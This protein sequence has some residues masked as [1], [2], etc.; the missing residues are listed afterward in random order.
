MD[1]VAPHRGASRGRAERNAAEGTGLTTKQKTLAGWGFLLSIFSLPKHPNLFRQVVKLTLLNL[2]LL[3]RQIV[4][5]NDVD[6]HCPMSLIARKAP[7]KKRSISVT[8]V[9]HK[10]NQ[11]CRTLL[12]PLNQRSGHRHVS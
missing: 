9:P 6:P 1:H 12:S 3:K 7:I 8:L 2:I 11:E 4:S 5:M 10:R